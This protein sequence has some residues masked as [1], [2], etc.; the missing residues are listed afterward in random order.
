MK[1]NFRTRSGFSPLIPLVIVGLVMLVGASAYLYSKKSAPSTVSTPTSQTNAPMP[2]PAEK[3]VETLVPAPSNQKEHSVAPAPTTPTHTPTTPVKSASPAP[4]A[5]PKSPTSTVSSPTATPPV[6][7]NFK[8]NSIA[9]IGCSN[10]DRSANGYANI[11]GSLKRLWPYYNTDS[12]ADEWGNPNASIWGSFDANVSQYEKPKAVWV[13]VC[14][15]SYDSVK[16]A[17]ANIKTR[18]PE[19][20]IYISPLNSYDPSELC[21]MIGSRGVTMTTG[22]ANQ[23]VQEGL[24]LAGPMNLGPLNSQQVTEDYFGKCHPNAEG[25]ALIGKQLADFF[26]KL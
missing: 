22:F 23:A 1:I 3:K 17:I 2:Q 20:K 15:F 25:Q 18:V 11:S 14:M 24:A 13:Q 19:A 10:T 21:T 12:M 6:V 8:Q 26:D 7:I 16:K 9:W 5:T 4:L